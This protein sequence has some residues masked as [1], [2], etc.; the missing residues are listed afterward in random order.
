MADAK[1][2]MM[3]WFPE[4]FI[5]ATR[6]WS[7]TERAIYR[8]LLDAQWIQGSL[9]NDEK[10]LIR[11]VGCSRKEWAAS[12][13]R[14]R[15]KFDLVDG[16]L[17][18]ARLE[19]HRAK[20]ISLRDKRRFGAQ[21]T[22]AKRYGIDS[23][24]ARSATRSA[25]RTA[26]AQRDAQRSHD[27]DT[28]ISVLRTDGKPSSIESD[29]RKEIFDLGVRILGEKHR[30]LVGKAVAQLGEA[31]VG[32]ILGGMAAKPPVDPVAYF[33]AATKPKERGVVV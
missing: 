11:L 1:L 20:A 18:N 29:P 17:K 4:S 22:N 2:L 28:E 31:R 25:T 9:P 7:F 19:E 3:P 10:E 16:E 12:W 14:V 33:A 21:K 6:G 26:L 30:S 23:D 15:Q 27:T 24:S 32:E 5:A 8:E 13:P